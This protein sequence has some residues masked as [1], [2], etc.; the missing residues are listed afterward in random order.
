MSGERG[1]EERGWEGERW[2]NNEEEEYNMRGK[3]E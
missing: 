3:G 1:S 2:K